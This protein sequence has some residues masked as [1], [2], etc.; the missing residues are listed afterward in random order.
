M[1]NTILRE[2]SHID[3]VTGNVSARLGGGG[4]TKSVSQTLKIID[5]FIKLFLPQLAIISVTYQVGSPSQVG[6]YAHLG[7]PK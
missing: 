5:F 7:C 6:I 1:H 2:A 4:G 3:F